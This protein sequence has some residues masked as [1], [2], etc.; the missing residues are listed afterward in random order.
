ML[1]CTDP[2]ILH[3]KVRLFLPSQHVR[4]RENIIIIDHDHLVLLTW[5]VQLACFHMKR[6][7]NI[8]TIIHVNYIISFRWW[9]ITLAIDTLLPYTWQLR[10]SNLNTLRIVNFVT[11]LTNT[12]ECFFISNNPMK[13]G[14]N[15]QL[16]FTVLY[17]FMVIVKWQ[18]EDHGNRQT[19]QLGCYCT[20]HNH[21]N[22]RVTS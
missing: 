8:S 15:N 16:N 7:N 10:T 9:F 19:C 18:S 11:R 2:W 17:E 21:V 1:L 14:P 4:Q 22:Q 12:S 5:R 20:T 13:H 3:L 6:Y